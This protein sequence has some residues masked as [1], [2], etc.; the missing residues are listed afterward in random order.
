VIRWALPI[1]G[2]LTDGDRDRTLAAL[3]AAAARAGSLDDALD[4]A[5]EVG[6][7]PARRTALASIAATV[8][9]YPAVSRVLDHAL[10]DTGAVWSVFGGASAFLAGRYGAGPVAAAIDGY[11]RWTGWEP[12]PGARSHR[13]RDDRRGPHGTPLHDLADGDLTDVVQE[14]TG[15]I[16]IVQQSLPAWTSPVQQELVVGVGDGSHAIEPVRHRRPS[17]TPHC[18]QSRGRLVG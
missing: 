12:G 15:P 5:E 3:A 2:E 7:W 18:R 10:A 1:A 13:D 4:V 8:G 14:V 11:S 17:S 6:D 9:A 16:R